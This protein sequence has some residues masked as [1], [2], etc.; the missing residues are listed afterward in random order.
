MSLLMNK[1]YFYRL[2]WLVDRPL[3]KIIPKKHRRRIYSTKVIA[4]EMGDGNWGV[5]SLDINFHGFG[6]TLK[7]AKKDF[8]EAFYYSLIAYTELGDLESFMEVAPYVTWQQ[9]YHNV[10]NLTYEGDEQLRYEE[11]E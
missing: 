11:F 8:Q 9:W 4:Q 1:A 10:D 7:S 2:G 6:S 3:P 5:Q